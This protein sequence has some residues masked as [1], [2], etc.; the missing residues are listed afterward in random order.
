MPQ[1]LNPVL[2]DPTATS[3]V[4]PNQDSQNASSM[5]QQQ[6]AQNATNAISTGAAYIM[7]QQNMHGAASSYGATYIGQVEGESAVAN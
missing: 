7:P 6:N 1:T 2:G 3:C 4:T 5:Q